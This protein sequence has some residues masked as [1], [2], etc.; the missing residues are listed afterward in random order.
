MAECGGEDVPGGAAGAGDGGGRGGAG[1]GAGEAFGRLELLVVNHGVWPPHDQPIATMSGGRSGGGRWGSTWT[2]C[3]GWCR[4]RWRRCCGRMLGCAERL[5]AGGGQARGHVVLVSLDG[6]AAGRGVPC[7]LCGEQGGADQPDEELVERA[8]AAGD[9][10]QLRGA[11]LGA[12]GDVGGNSGRPGGVQESAGSDSA[13]P[14]G[15]AGRDCGA[16]CVSCVRRWA[17]FVSGEMFNVN[18]GAV[19]VG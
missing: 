7:G 8:G 13:G 19:L 1:G 16:D 14:G 5:A 12:D 11:G 10:V 4:R 6:G 17:G 2:A 18:G 9:F 3:S 15:G